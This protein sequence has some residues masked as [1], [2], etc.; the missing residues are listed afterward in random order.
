MSDQ[1]LRVP[2][3]PATGDT[4]DQQAAV[5]GSG[6]EDDDDICAFCFGSK[7]DGTN[8]E[9]LLCGHASLACMQL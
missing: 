8:V 7:R 9:G 3:E 2:G 4:A 1:L 6:G 5:T